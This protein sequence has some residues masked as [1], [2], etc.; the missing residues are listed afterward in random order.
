MIVVDTSVW[1]DW[2]NDLDT[3]QTHTVGEL[4]AADRALGLTDVVLT[5][6]LQGLRS[7]RLARQVDETL[8][9]H[10]ILTLDGLE[11]FRRAATLYRRCRAAGVTIRRTADCLIAVVCI[12]EKVPLLHADVDFDRLS[13]QTELRVV[14]PA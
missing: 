10:E 7:D 5:E 9:A 8:S 3:P 2:F 6:M 12:R 11:D 14:A 4:L 1:I 13:E